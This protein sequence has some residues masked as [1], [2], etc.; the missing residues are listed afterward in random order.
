MAESHD[1]SRH[2]KAYM[3]VFAALAVFTVVTVA[4][5]TLDVTKGLGI[6]IALAIAATKASLVAAIF[7]HLKWERSTV[8]WG[9]LALCVIFFFVLILVPV[10]T[11]SD[12]PPQVKY[13][14]WG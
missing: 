12:W 5:S 11:V 14:T 9:T 10:L 7:M 2:V 8:I 4:V 3:A 1:V 13:G 6:G